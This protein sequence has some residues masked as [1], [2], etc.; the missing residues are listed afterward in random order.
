MVGLPAAGKS[1]YAK[2]HNIP[3]VSSDELRALLLDD[4]SDQSQ[5]RRIF[6]LLRQ[7]V[8]MRFEMGRP[9][10]ALDATSITARERRTW[11]KLAQLYGVAVEA[12]FLETPL[13]VCK[14]RNRVRDR[15]V[16][17]DVMDRMARRL[18]R[19]SLDEG[20]RRVTVVTPEGQVS[21]AAIAAAPATT[22]GPEQS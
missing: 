10:T 2:Q 1:T 4:V 20:F 17:D 18:Q 12:V 7:L 5:N 15:V 13:D 8:R 21:A 14:Q 3:Y 11:I 19:P 22:T 16:P 6:A 9:V